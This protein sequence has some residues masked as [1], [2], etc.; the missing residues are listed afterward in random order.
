M[1]VRDIAEMVVID[2][3]EDMCVRGKVLLNTF[4]KIQLENGVYFSNAGF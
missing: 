3:A 2:E 4:S 1:I